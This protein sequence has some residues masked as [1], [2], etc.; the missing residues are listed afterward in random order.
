MAKKNK[1]VASNSRCLE[2][3]H[4]KFLYLLTLNSMF[5]N[6]ITTED[7]ET[8]VVFTSTHAIKE[9]ISISRWDTSKIDESVLEN[10][11]MHLLLLLPH[12]ILYII[13][14]FIHSFKKEKKIWSRHISYQRMSFHY[15]LHLNFKIFLVEFG[16]K[17]KKKSQ[18]S[19]NKDIY[20]AAWF[21]KRKVE[22]HLFLF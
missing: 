3:G 4:L 15:C 8:Y 20:F 11:N 5:I 10:I 7:R 22:F 9:V 13:V 12:P 17:K 1:K 14:N 2:V 16:I 21:I 6:I 19:K 18:L